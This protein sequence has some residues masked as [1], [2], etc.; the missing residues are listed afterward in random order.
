LPQSDEPGRRGRDVRSGVLGVL[1]LL[2]LVVGVPVVLMVFVGYPLPTAAPSHDWLTTAL[3]ATLL[4]KV[5]AC[6][7]WLAWAHFVVCLIAEWRALRHGRLPAAVLA[8]GGSQLLARRLIASALLLTGL[9]TLAP[10]GGAHSHHPAAGAS[11]IGSST[12]GSSAA[13][14][15]AA[16]ATAKRATSVAAARTT[17]G[18]AAT[19]DLSATALPPVRGTASVPSGLTDGQHKYYVVAPPEGRRYDSLWEIADRTMGNPLRYK[20]IFELNKDRLQPDGR[21]LQDA[22]LIQPGWTLRL[23]SDAHGPGVQITPAGPAPLP[24]A[25]VPAVPAPGPGHRGPLESAAGVVTAADR[26]GTDAKLIRPAAHSADVSTESVSPAVATVHATSDLAIRSIADS[27]AE[28]DLIG[29]GLLLSGVLVALSAR[30]GPFA[31][32]EPAELALGL[33]A[34][35]DLAELLDRVLRQLAVARAAQARDLPVPLL[36]WV[37][38]SQVVLHL[39][40]GDLAEPPAP[41][42]AAADGLSWSVDPTIVPATDGPAP[43]PG[44][45]AVGSARGFEVF[46]DLERAPGLIGIGGDLVAARELVASMAVQAAT[47]RWSDGVHVT[48]VGFG[49]GE[50]LTQLDPTSLTQVG[51]LDEVLDSLEQEHRT[52]LAVQADLGVHGVLAGRQAGRGADWRPRLILLSGLPT[53]DEA[54]R[55][56]RLTSTDRSSVI[57]VCVG[58]AP[59]ARWRFVI[60]SGG[61]LD[62]GPLGATVSAH[63]L[64]RNGS[65]RLVELARQAADQRHR[66]AATMMT[67][68]PRALVRQIG[69][70]VMAARPSPA[71]VITLLGPVAVETPTA[72]GTPTPIE[73]DRQALLTELVV[74]AALHPDGLSLAVLRAALW[75]HGAD[76]GLVATTVAQ[77]QQWLGVAPDG[78]PRLRSGADGALHLSTD[79]QTDWDRLRQLAAGAAGED[80]LAD[81]LDALTL[82]NGPAFSGTPPLRY[83]WL[84]FV[85]AARDARCV[86]TAVS[87]RAAKLLV[88]Q[89][90][91]PEAS[92]T[93]RAGLIL[94]PTAEPLWRE[95]LLLAS[96]EGP[97]AT[98]AVADELYLTLRAHRVVAE[99]QTDELV[100]QVA[101]DYRRDLS[102]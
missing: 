25:A 91:R 88:A 40:D 79:V 65:R 100:D 74:C 17:A 44:L 33:S 4:I 77:A 15:S 1:G 11:V 78:R 48:M 31:A 43:Y 46:V 5:L 60:D 84:A 6:V 70:P 61:Q 3:T 51:R 7:V 57:S 58:D 71:V 92:A 30:R 49:D 2:G 98:V 12:P 93:L 16:G 80:E 19:A 50:D 42:S 82:F 38:R 87:R 73:P 28:R 53:S 9:A 21:T 24:S 68:D 63:R 76:A 26:A 89:H 64:D 56:H 10:H 75:P 102:A 67:A 14:S 85:R 13:G 36:A 99:A 47:S 8:G 86:G 45:V 83:G 37:S 35:D 66:S 22:N 97:A 18:L 41:W 101:P 55:L 69:P 62:L 96:W 29:G 81:L 59:S 90:R 39:V 94:V 32:A 52:L 54:A 95:L 27:D 72:M 20:D 23:P 34:R